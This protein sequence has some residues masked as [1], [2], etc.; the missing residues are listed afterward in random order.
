M[1]RE[2]FVEKMIQFKAFKGNVL[3]DWNVTR[4]NAENIADVVGEE[5]YQAIY[6]ACVKVREGK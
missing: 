1:T 3:Q 6:D 2:E 4:E 5:C